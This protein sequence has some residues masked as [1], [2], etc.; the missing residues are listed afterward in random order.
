MLLAEYSPLDDDIISC[1]VS[2]GLVYVIFKPT[3]GGG[4]SLASYC[5]SSIVMRGRTAKLFI[6]SFLRLFAAS[7]PTE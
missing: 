4:D 1:E 2:L 5:M 7:G 6:S 3:E